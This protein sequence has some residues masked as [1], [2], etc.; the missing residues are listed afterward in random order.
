MES[1]MNRDEF[2][3][4]FFGEAINLFVPVGIRKPDNLA[5]TKKGWEK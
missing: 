2:V 4:I 5:R 3:E 1:Q